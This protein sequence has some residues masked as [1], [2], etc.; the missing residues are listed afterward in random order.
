[1][2][3]RY[4]TPEDAETLWTLYSGSW[5][6]QMELGHSVKEYQDMITAKHIKFIGCFSGS[7]AVGLAIA[8]DVVKWGYLDSLFVRENFRKQG[9]GTAML[10]LLISSNPKWEKLETALLDN[11]TIYVMKSMGFQSIDTLN[12][13]VKLIER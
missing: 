8:V 1:M 11:K 12:W 7:A 13:A 4:A 9:I 6:N 2:N 3:I 5:S 10:D